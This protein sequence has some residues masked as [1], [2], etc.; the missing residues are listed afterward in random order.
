M[1]YNTYLKKMCIFCLNRLE[2]TNVTASTA[3][4]N[5]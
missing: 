1:L 4:D 2:T 5:K 3:G